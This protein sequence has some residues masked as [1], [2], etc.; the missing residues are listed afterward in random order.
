MPILPVDKI[1]RLN[2]LYQIVTDDGQVVQF[3]LN[4]AQVGLCE[5]L[6][7]R[8]VILK[9]RQLGFCL[10]PQTR[11]LTADL[12]WIPIADLQPR[13]ELVGVD[14]QPAGGKG[15]TRRMRL[16][17]VHGIVW[18]K[19][20][21]YKI[22]FD[23]GRHVICSGKHPW[24]SKLTNPQALWRSIESNSKKKLKV[25]VKVRWITQPWDAPTIE[26]GWISGMLDGEGSI[27]RPNTAPSASI[28]QLQGPVWDRLKEYFKDRGYN[29]CIENDKPDRPSKFG[30]K[31]VS[32]IVVGRTNE[33][34]RLIGQTRPTRFI[35]NHFWQGKALPGRRNGDTGWSTITD[36]EPLGMTDLID[37]QTSTGTYI[38][39]GFVSH[40]TTFIDLFILDECLF[41]DTVEGGIIC[42]NLDNAKKIFRRKILFPYQHM[43]C[44]IP[45]LRQALTESKTELEFSNGSVIS[46]GTSLRSGT[47]QYLHIS[48]FGKIAQKYPDKAQEIVTGALE[49]VAP[50]Q[51]VFIESTAAGRYGYFYDYCMRAKAL[52]D[53][54]AQL[55]ALDYRF[56]FF[57]WWQKP[58]NQLDTKVP[59]PSKLIDYFTKLESRIG[60]KLSDPQKY[61]YV[62]KHEA[63]GSDTK[64]EHPSTP[65]EAFEA[66]IQGAYFTEEIAV[67]RDQ[68]RICSVP[69]EESVAIDTWW[70]LGMNDSMS[71]WFTQDVGR[72]IHL[73][74][75]YE[76]NGKGLA[77]YARELTE[78][79]YHYGTHNAP[80]DIRVRELAGEGKSR[81]ESALALGIRF[82]VVNRPES[83]ADS[84]QAARG[85]FPI[86][87]LDQSY[88]AAGLVHLE[89]YRKEWNER[90]GCYNNNP[91]HDEHS[92]GAD[93]FQTL[94]L[95]HSWS[96]TFLQTARPVEPVPMSQAFMM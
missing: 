16:S 73:I 52:K 96:K 53:S 14:E 85:I 67:M 25:G 80:H 42:D 46:V 11:V 91:L 30:R 48:E 84:I 4:D 28:S 37:L 77:H 68:G 81:L 60:Q 55:T 35:H 86:I 10:A 22:T 12:R 20:N 88:C 21:A 27:T 75:Y 24:L 32:Q 47:Y 19:R 31:P 78:R 13:Q 83:K 58:N 33:L 36:I 44:D 74:D 40:N 1:W 54:K 6:W 69:V 90:L 18:V 66:S 34:F 94:A 59:I 23:D 9:A 50:G 29:Y 82:N 71:I 87:W 39:E 63:L 3:R 49:T 89:S 15:T 70:D 64:Q 72:E 57:P 79:G 43:G 41:R 45:A 8:N 51:M 76:N 92:N 2:N 5:R 38:A 95:G 93:A 17:V 26:D 65:E 56:H 61:W 7:A 62:K